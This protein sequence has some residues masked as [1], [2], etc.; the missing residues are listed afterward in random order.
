V[1]GVMMMMMMVVVVEVFRSWLKATYYDDDWTWRTFIH[2]VLAPEFGGY[3]VR[4]ICAAVEGYFL[5]SCAILLGN[6]I[7]WYAEHTRTLIKKNTQS[8]Q[9]ICLTPRWNRS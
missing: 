5:S 2:K 8:T 9:F 1:N 6:Q 4:A 7:S 3:A